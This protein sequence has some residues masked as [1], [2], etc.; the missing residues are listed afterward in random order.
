[1]TSI[2]KVNSTSEGS[3]SQDTVV[4]VGRGSHSNAL[5][6]RR[7]FT[8][9]TTTTNIT[10]TATSNNTNNSGYPQTSQKQLNISPV[11]IVYLVL[12]PLNGTF[13]RKTIPLSVFPSTQK[14]GRVTNSR[15]STSSS[16]G[17]FDTKVLSRQHAEVWA[18]LEGRA[19]IRDTRSSNGT[20]LNG[21]RLSLE[22]VES[23]PRELRTND[24]LEF[25]IDILSEDENGI[26]HHKVS[27]VV[28]VV[29]VRRTKADVHTADL[30]PNISLEDLDPLN[31]IDQKEAKDN[32]L[33]LMPAHV[34]DNLK[35]QSL[36]DLM[37]ANIHE[38][39]AQEIEM[40]KL[41]N[42][43]VERKR[44]ELEEQ[45]SRK[46]SQQTYV[47]ET[48]EILESTRIENAALV[49]KLDQI[50]KEKGNDDK[51]ISTSSTSNS[52]K[53]SKK[54]MKFST[55]TS[56]LAFFVALIAMVYSAYEYRNKL[57]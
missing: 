26:L 37:V 22:S 46:K 14:I 51:Q 2:S 25:G 40:R 41:L 23:E 13:E 24:Q 56:L 19:W 45:E 52:L 7:G 36:V 32:E 49:K 21:S 11:A 57:M 55:Y 31:F 18:D 20:Y 35:L 42:K 30:V 28:E 27:A 48:K 54:G 9:N 5:L 17:Y 43:T 15:N 3:L 44:I 53:K 47:D 39:N 4:P 33:P 1:M 34:E 8:T 29:P 10:T 38:L 12:V 16:N 50:Q 6:G